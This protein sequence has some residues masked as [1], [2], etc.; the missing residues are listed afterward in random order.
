MDSDITQELDRLQQLYDTTIANISNTLRSATQQASIQY[1]LSGVP[2]D[3]AARAEANAKRLNVLLR[4]KLRDV[5]QALQLQQKPAVPPLAPE[6]RAVSDAVGIIL[7]KRAMGT[8][9]STVEPLKNIRLVSERRN[10]RSLNEIADLIRQRE[11]RKLT[12]RARSM[13]DKATGTSDAMLLQKKEQW[14]L[15]EQL[16]EMEKDDLPQLTFSPIS[17][18]ELFRRGTASKLPANWILSVGSSLR[19]IRMPSVMVSFR[20]ADG[21]VIEAAPADVARAGQLDTIPLYRIRRLKVGRNEQAFRSWLDWERFSATSADLDVFD[22]DALADRMVHFAKTIVIELHAGSYY[23]KLFAV[24]VTELTMVFETAD[25]MNAFLA[26]YMTLFPEETLGMDPEIL[27]SSNLVSS[28]LSASIQFA[29]TSKLLDQQ[30][31]EDTFCL[32]HHVSPV[33][34]IKVKD[35]I[36][37]TRYEPLVDLVSLMTVAPRLPIC[38]LW[39]RNVARAM[40]VERYELAK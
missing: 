23:S 18:S 15:F 22:D 2:G 40:P 17:R 14:T 35:R 21:I 19:G 1:A 36:L 5:N 7:A 38:N 12:R 13:V 25:A 11:P 28:T 39:R 30:A 9:Q 24:D 6:L 34:F 33:D 37:S 26:C 10:E 8:L 3:T 29:T 31:G 20:K 32:Q 16:V 4:D 27:R